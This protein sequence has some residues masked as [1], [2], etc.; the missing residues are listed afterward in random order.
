MAEVPQVL[1]TKRATDK[2]RNPDDLE[3]V[4]HVTNPS[5]WAVLGAC[6]A[7]LAGLF[8]WGVFGS[9]STSVHVMGAVVDGKAVCYLSVDE[10]SA[11]SVGDQATI[12]DGSV[13]VS[14]VATVPSSR[15]EV[16]QL[17]GGDFLTAA[18][19]QS[20]WVYRISLE[21]DVSQ[22]ARDVP[23]PITITVEQVAPI[24][25]IFRDLN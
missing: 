25:L 23:L 16:R 8:A 3:R 4:I 14:E 6:V 20:D 17:L 5:I 15:D 10:V 24:S 12:G 1:F 22:L 18:L 19:V 13:T 9:V 11:V 7:L 21:G 2:L